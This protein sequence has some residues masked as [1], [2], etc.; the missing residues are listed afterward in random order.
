MTAYHEGTENTKLT[1]SNWI[2]NFVC[3]AS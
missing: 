3:F 2:N 1:K